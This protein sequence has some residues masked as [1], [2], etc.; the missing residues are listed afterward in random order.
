MDCPSSIFEKLWAVRGGDTSDEQCVKFAYEALGSHGWTG[1]HSVTF[2][3]VETKHL[4][5]WDDA[6]D[7]IADLG[8]GLTLDTVFSNHTAHI[9]SKKILPRDI[10]KDENG[11]QMFV[12]ETLRSQFDAGILSWEDSGV[13][14]AEITN[15][16]RTLFL[17]FHYCDS[18]G[19][20][21]ADRIKVVEDLSHLTEANGY[22]DLK[23]ARPTNVK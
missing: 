9:R 15:G 18:W 6:E 11:L 10:V 20:G 17:I 23:S 4:E 1:V 2:N 16:D 13:A 5:D 21:Y 14:C 19:L 8:M 22:Y 12:L 7:W 3:E